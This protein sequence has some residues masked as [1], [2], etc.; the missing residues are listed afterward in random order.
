MLSFGIG[1]SLAGLAGLLIGP[2]GSFDLSLGFT[3]MLLGFAAAVLGGFGS[4]GGTVL[5]AVF[6]GLTEE[7]LGGQMLPMVLGDTALRYRS[8][9]PFVLM[10]VVIA[11]KPQGLFGR[12][13]SRL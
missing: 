3:L 4:L 8:T 9:L 11:V 7:L 5:G 10:L 13:T 6:I 1:A 12:A 2:L